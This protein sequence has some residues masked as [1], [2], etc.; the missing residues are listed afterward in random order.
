MSSLPTYVLPRLAQHR[1]SSV[2]TQPECASSTAAKTRSASSIRLT[3]W[4]SVTYPWRSESIILMFFLDPSRHTVCPDS[5]GATQIPLLIWES[6]QN[7]A[8]T[9]KPA[10]D[11]FLCIHL[12]EMPMEHYCFSFPD[13]KA[14][15][16]SPGLVSRERSPNLLLLLEWSS[17]WHVYKPILSNCREKIFGFSLHT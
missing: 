6:N 8:V 5:R 12:I 2:R 10:T 15:K 17:H 14:K 9:F 13:E 4:L 7:F 11:G 3:I 16:F 1:H